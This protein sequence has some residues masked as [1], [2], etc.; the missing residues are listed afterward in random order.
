M[1]AAVAIVA[2]GCGGSSKDAGA[3]TTTTAGSAGTT[4]VDVPTRTTTGATLTKT[5]ARVRA[6]LRGIPQHG[7]VLGNP[8]APVTIVEYGK[9][10]CPTC[11]AVHRD[12]LPTVIERYV[13]TGKASLEFRGLAGDA[14]SASRDLALATYAAAAQ[15]GGW[16]F[17]QLAYLRSLEGAQP[18]TTTESPAQ[19]AAALGL[20]CEAPRCRRCAAGVGG[21]G[22]GGGERRVDRASVLL[23]GVPPAPASEAGPP[24]RRPDAS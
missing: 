12:V 23:P 10:A 3:P 22:P 2:A 8:K 5:A 6:Q 21:A 15:R 17:L 14:P 11:A 20:E 13:R 9:F 19:L 16:D 18:G 1:L 4:T 7:L 24:V